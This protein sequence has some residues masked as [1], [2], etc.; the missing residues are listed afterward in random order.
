MAADLPDFEVESPPCKKFKSG[1]S[2]TANGAHHWLQDPL[3]S[4]QQHRFWW[5][6]ISDEKFPLNIPVEELI[7]NLK[8]KNSDNLLQAAE[9][10]NKKQQTVL[11][12]WVRSRKLF[13][14]AR[15]I[16]NKHITLD[17]SKW[18]AIN[19]AVAPI[20]ATVEAKLNKD[21]GVLQVKSN[22][23]CINDFLKN[24]HYFDGK[25]CDVD[26]AWNLPHTDDTFNTICM[27]LVKLCDTYG[28]EHNIQHA[29]QA[30]F[31]PQ[32]TRA[33]LQPIDRAPR[34][35]ACVH[36][37]ACT[38]P[39]SKH[40]WMTRSELRRFDREEYCEC[41]C[42]GDDRLCDYMAPEPPTTCNCGYEGSLDL[43]L[44]RFGINWVPNHVP[45]LV[46]LLRRGRAALFF[47]RFRVLSIGRT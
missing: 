47:S 33:C 18:D 11:K 28:F 13:N 16:I 17:A 46:S 21:L 31:T 10:V 9:T 29:G 25:W 34:A 24:E 45:E 7:N 40:V 5:I 23:Y 19:A 44:E 20:R 22:V 38:P 35:Y 30:G 42:A 3:T 8:R 12:V 36:Q 4:T 43:C 14:I 2:S 1:G 27:K 32:C 37:K 41:G 26:K 15:D 39:R 6:V